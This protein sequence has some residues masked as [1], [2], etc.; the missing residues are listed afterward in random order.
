M[1]DEDATR[2]KPGPTRAERAGN[3]VD[4]A[5]ARP[6]DAASTRRARGRPSSAPSS[7]SSRTAGCA[8]APSS[9]TSSAGP[10]RE[11]GRAP[12]RQ[13][14]AAQGS[15]PDH[16][17]PPPRPRACPYLGATSIPIVDGV[18]LVLR[19]VRRGAGA[20]RGE[21]RRGARASPSIR[22][23]RGDRP[24]RERRAG[25]HRHRRAPARLPSC[26]TACCAPRS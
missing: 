7:P 5:R 3:G 9:R 23:P 19:G 18:E 25:Q 22:P 4:G 24:R 10:S 8:S 20:A 14:G 16:R 1:T 6:G 12:L 13:R 11:A 26:T 15:A 21:G 17:Q 2:P